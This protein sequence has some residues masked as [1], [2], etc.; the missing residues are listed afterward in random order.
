[1]NFET[2]GKKMLQIYRDTNSSTSIFQ[3]FVYLDQ[4]EQVIRNTYSYFGPKNNKGNNY[5]RNN[6]QN[7]A[8]Y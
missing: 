3:D 1:M 5:Q 2:T 7:N 6:N 8:L 4:K